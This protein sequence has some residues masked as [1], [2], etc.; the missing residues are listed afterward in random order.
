MLLLLLLLL[1]L[2]LVMTENN[3]NNND[4]DNHNTVTIYKHTF[5][6]SYAIVFSRI[7]LRPLPPGSRCVTC[8]SRNNS[9][10]SSRSRPPYRGMRSLYTWGCGWHRAWGSLQV[11]RDAWHVMRDA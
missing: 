4:T 2:V 11:M 1:L 9:D 6:S 5:L 10:S 3:N 7:L 8:C